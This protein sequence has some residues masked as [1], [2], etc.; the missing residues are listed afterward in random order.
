MIKTTFSQHLDV[1]FFFL[2]TLL[3]CIDVFEY[4]YGFLRPFMLSLHILE[5]CECHE[6]VFLEIDYLRRE[7][8]SLVCEPIV[9][10]FK[11]DS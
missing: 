2:S 7:K 4:F 9:S 1:V 10:H 11:L 5:S 3:D 6:S 8:V